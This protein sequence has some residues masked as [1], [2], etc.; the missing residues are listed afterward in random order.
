MIK[1]SDVYLK[2]RLKFKL[3]KDLGKEKVIYNIWHILCI[4]IF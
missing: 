1:F 3:I 4:F 2:N